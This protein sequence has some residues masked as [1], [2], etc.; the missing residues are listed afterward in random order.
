M[1]VQFDLTP[2]S[3]DFANQFDI[4][5]EGFIDFFNL[6]SM[7]QGTMIKGQRADVTLAADMNH[8]AHEEISESNV[9][10][11]DVNIAEL[12]FDATKVRV[13]YQDIQKWGQANAIDRKD[14]E[15]MNALGHHIESRLV[16]NLGDHAGTQITEVDYK[17]ALAMA[18]AEVNTKPGFKG[19]QSIAFVNTMDYYRYLAD[20]EVATAQ[21]LF[22]MDYVKNFLGYSVI[23]FSSQVEKGTVFVTADGNLNLAHIPANGP[24]FSALELTPSDN[25][26]IGVKHYLNDNTGDIF[27]KVHFGLEAFAERTDAVVQVTIDEGV[28]A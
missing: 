19:S 10:L 22:G 21:N 26:L 14:R 18:K 12:K 17:S 28:A 15:L 2:Y 20:S 3:K 11:Y 25:K 9:R 1:T 7:G 27:T 24:A 16:A 23:F 8:E 13:S 5:T 4:R 6:M